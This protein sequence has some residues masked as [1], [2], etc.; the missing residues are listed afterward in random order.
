MRI[1]TY[2]TV[3]VALLCL[4]TA[5]E[6]THTVPKQKVQTLRVEKQALHKTLH[7][8]GTIQAI[9]ENSII[10]PF[11]AVIE[12]MPVNYGEALEKH[13]LAFTLNSS[14]LQKQYNDTL[15]DYLKSKDSFS[16]A[17]SKFQGA[18]ELWEAGLVSK[19]TFNSEQSSLNNARISMLQNQKK[20]S[21]LQVKM[22]NTSNDWASLSLAEFE[23]VRSALSGKNNQIKIYSPHSGI[24]LYP[25]KT[26]EDKSSQLRVGSVVK[27]GQVLGLIGDLD[28]IRIE[29]DI[30]EIDIDKVHRGMKAKI[31]GAAFGDSPLA[32]ELVAINGQA[33]A[34]S[35][36]SLPVFNAIVVAK[37]LNSKQK[38]R[39]RIGMSATVELALD[40]YKQLIIPI[41]AIQF[42]KGKSIVQV[43]SAKGASQPRTI[44]TGA[45]MQ[46]KVVVV[47]GL[48][49]GEEIAIHATH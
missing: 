40:D 1:T 15:T 39:I 37:H 26:G 2:Y 47:S 22:G 10:S 17:Q 14:E 49:E 36:N 35:G 41:T 32:G 25:P 12:A 19:N 20:F 18:Q 24:L 45:A 6:R 30:P 31:R 5:C 4:L 33:L 42:D 23:K 48:S 43:I 8:P 38:Q 44:R 46:D 16:I 21:D 7:F 34:A 13:A 11:E 29:I 3:L 27:A 9:Q 28:G